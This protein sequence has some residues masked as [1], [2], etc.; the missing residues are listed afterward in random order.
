MDPFLVLATYAIV[1]GL[2]IAILHFVGRRER[3]VTP[4]ALFVTIEIVAVWPALWPVNNDYLAGAGPFSAVLVATALLGL[5]II[6]V[7]FGGA[8][9]DATV[10]RGAAHVPGPE[11]LRSIAVGLTLLV[12]GLVAAGF[13][14]FGG[15]PPLLTGG[16]SSLFDPLANQ[17]Q[18]EIIRESR[19]SMTKG[20]T[21]LGDEYSGQG[22]LNVAIRSGWQVAV[23]VAVL[24]WSWK[25]T[26]GSLQAV[27]VVSG[28]ALV[29]LGSTGVRSSVV[30][31]AIAA[32]TALAI[33]YRMKM[34]HIVFA[35]AALV[36]FILLIMPLSKGE[37]AGVTISERA[38]SAT[39]RVTD[40]NGQH[41]ARIV[42]LIASERLDI[43][44]GNV[45]WG[46]LAAM[47]PGVGGEDPFALR[48]TRLS[49]GSNS[50]STTGYST[51][52]QFGLMYADG[53][54]VGVIIGYL[55][56]GA[57]LG[58]GWR[59]VCRLRSPVG[60]AVAAQAAILLGF[61]S[62]TG[63]PGVLSTGLVLGLSLFI[64]MGPHGW[65][66]VA[67]RVLG[68]KGARRKMP[69]TTRVMSRQ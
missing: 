17:E 12:G 44:W 23:S 55:L 52:T 28:L 34:R 40:G 3:V 43:Q 32:V 16:F 30:M 8:A 25:H 56:S 51:P 1:C 13:A 33:R 18:V 38:A 10:W 6:Y 61:M 63:I 66:A 65:S 39:T 45:L 9:A 50:A 47:A 57:L 31:C 4:V 62:V 37:S 5:V 14:Q 22:I 41:N 7:A 2:V 21:L 60:A 46:K 11:S 19:R 15:L 36:G 48:L 29:F 53:G 20:H 42:G 26:R 27:V 68:G 35:T 24:F 59:W 67:A 69:A 49:F 54:P 58:V 64:C